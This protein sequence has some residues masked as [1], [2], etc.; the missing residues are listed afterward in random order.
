MF[1]L[2]VLTAS[3]TY[4][5]IDVFVSLCLKTLLPCLSMLL[6]LAQWIT[7]FSRSTRQLFFKSLPTL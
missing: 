2:L 5:R 1:Q 3:A 6:F 4:I 7:N